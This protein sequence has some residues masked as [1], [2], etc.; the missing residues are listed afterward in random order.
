MTTGL[1]DSML[2][3]T[4]ADVTVVAIISPDFP[5]PIITATHDN[6]CGELH[7]PA[8]TSPFAAWDFFLHE[9]RDVLVSKADLQTAPLKKMISHLM[10]IHLNDDA[11]P[12]ASHMSR[13]TPF[14]F[15]SQVKELNFMVNQGIIKPASDQP[16]KWS[17]L[18]SWWISLMGSGSQWTGIS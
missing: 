1:Q 17:I 6:R 16:S 3:D 4:G 12:F 9:F 10:K 18:W 15:Q 14:A 7:L 5:K 13:P 8:T 11:V 2:P